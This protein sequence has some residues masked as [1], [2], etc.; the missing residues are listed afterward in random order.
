[1]TLPFA[2]GARGTLAVLLL[3]MLAACNDE[4]RLPGVRL[5]PEDALSGTPT[6]ETFVAPGPLA[7]PAP[8]VNGD[9]PQMGG[10]ATH[11]LGHVALSPAPQLAW[12]TKIG[13]GDGRRLRVTADPV[14]AA[15]RI[16]T[17]DAANTVAATS[18]GGQALWQ[19][20]A[21]PVAGRQAGDATG[22]GLAYADGR[23]YV[24]TGYG[25][26]LALDAASGGILWR[27]RFDA[28]IGGAPAVAGGTVFVTARDSTAWAIRA[29]DGRELWNTKG[30]VSPTGILGAATPAVS[31]DTVVIPMVS[32]EVLGLSTADGSRK[33]VSMLSGRR[34]GIAFANIRDVTGDPVIAGDTVIAGSSSGRVAAVSLSG[35]RR[36]L[37]EEGVYGGPVAAF[38]NAVF[39]VSDENRLIRLDAASGQRVW[40][41]D[42][43]FYEKTRRAGR[44][45]DIHVQYGPVLAGGRLRIASSDGVLRSFDPAT[46]ALVAEAQ[47]PGGAASSMA[48]AGG[49]LYLVSGN[50]QLLAFR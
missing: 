28:G 21:V 32:G 40:A 49:V 31:G 26:L 50:G 35:D 34:L 27:Q 43:P 38:G 29:A 25:E 41:I 3:A 22:G 33:W 36:W 47:I 37:T 8:V 5:D 23:L 4:P 48:V 15:G 7:L 12:S 18:T 19:T 1:M 14:V 2:T 20:S 30:M 46:G 45:R 10:A 16:F 13:R 9:W 6:P 11:R 42:L 44:R 24:T 39:L 17:M